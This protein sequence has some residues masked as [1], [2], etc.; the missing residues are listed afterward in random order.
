MGTCTMEIKLRNIIILL[1]LLF[2]TNYS[3]NYVPFAVKGKTMPYTPKTKISIKGTTASG[4]LFIKPLQGSF[5]VDSVKSKINNATLTLQDSS[6]NY[7]DSLGIYYDFNVSESGFFNEAIYVW[8]H[9]VVDSFSIPLEVIEPVNVLLAATNTSAVAG[10]QNNI[11]I[12]WVDPNF[13][14]DD[15]ITET[16]TF[17]TYFDLE[18]WEANKE[19]VIIQLSSE[20]TFSAM[21]YDY[22]SPSSW[23]SMKRYYEV[24]DSQRFRVNA[25]PYNTDNSYLVIRG[26]DADTLGGTLLA[27]MITDVDSLLDTSLVNLDYEILSVELQIYAPGTGKYGYF[28]NYIYDRTEPSLDSWQLQTRDYVLG[29]PE[30]YFYDLANLNYNIT[31][32]NH[33][34]LGIGKTYDYRVRAYNATNDEYSDWD[35]S[36]TAIVVSTEPPIE[37]DADLFVGEEDGTGTFLS[38]S[39]SNYIP[40]SH[41]QAYF[42][43]ADSLP[44][45]QTIALIAGSVFQW[46]FELG[47]NDPIAFD[48]SNLP[49]GTTIIKTAGAAPAFTPLDTLYKAMDISKWVYANSGDVEPN[50]TTGLYPW[51]YRFDSYFSSTDLASLESIGM[52]RL[53]LDST[54]YP[55]AINDIG[56]GLSTSGD[57][58]FMTVSDDYPWTIRNFSHTGNP[59]LYVY[60]GSSTLSPPEVFSNIMV[61][62][63]AEYTAKFKN[64]DNLTIKGIEFRGADYCTV[65]FEDC[66]N[67]IFSQDTVKYFSYRAVLTEN[68]NGGLIDSCLLNSGFNEIGGNGRIYYEYFTAQGG[69]EFLA[70]S[71]NIDFS[72]SLA[73]DIT[74]FSFNFNCQVNPPT[75]LRIFNNYIGTS[76]KGM[77]PYFRPFQIGNDFNY[78]QIEYFPSGVEIFN[79]YFEHTTVPIKLSVVPDL[80]MYFNVFAN[81]YQ[82]T[83][84]MLDHGEYKHEGTFSNQPLFSLEDGQW[85]DIGSS[86]EMTIFNNTFYE[87]ENSLFTFMGSRFKSGNRVNFW[88][89]ALINTS[90]LPISDWLRRDGL[91]SSSKRI[92]FTI[93]S[94]GRDAWDIR[95]NYSYNDDRNSTDDAVLYGEYGTTSW[96]AENYYSWSELDALLNNTYPDDRSVGNTQSS[97]GSVSAILDINNNYEPTSVLIEAGDVGNAG[98]TSTSIFGILGAN[99]YDRWGNQVTN[100]TELI[101]GTINI[102]ANNK[103]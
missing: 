4:S 89:N 76:Y 82:Q 1:V 70:G 15:I 41:F 16:N 12:N 78:N 18:N 58:S 100:A 20:H 33:S 75:N 28:N 74:T 71:D 102:G 87:N 54:E 17:Q 6:V 91:T 45:D 63:G 90:S 99:F 96:T 2:V 8:H 56:W 95:N 83:E 51:K 7:G 40:M 59:A 60:T 84:G 88:N 32:Y 30:T 3:Q 47:D 73:L 19:G 77:L 92:E 49:N 66:N 48:F 52:G 9:G 97:L 14:L 34:S 36:N 65:L 31:T 53:L 24:A 64:T 27:N 85:D 69:V 22:S 43:N 23:V 80:K 94:T 46:R 21:V 98:Y 35:T 25:Y 61:Y 50:P 11:L 57:S 5:R 81:S 26:Y 55:I 13:D 101:N 44:P 86:F 72:N 37:T 67:F 103:K 38:N 10:T 79:N 42:T 62:G 29:E 68:L 93:S 39:E